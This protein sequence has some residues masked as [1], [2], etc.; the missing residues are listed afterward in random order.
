MDRWVVAER[1]CASQP[2]D[3]IRAGPRLVV[4]APGSVEEVLGKWSG[5]LR[6]CSSSTET[7][8]Q[9]QEA[10]RK[11]PERPLAGWGEISMLST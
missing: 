1:A 7:G 6:G 4:G 3:W 9:S 8:V 2:Y 5:S 10:G 11:P